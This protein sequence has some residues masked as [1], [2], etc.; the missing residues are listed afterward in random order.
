MYINFHYDRELN[1]LSPSSPTPC[2]WNVSLPTEL[3]CRSDGAE[4][5]ERNGEFP[6]DRCGNYR[7]IQ[8]YL[9]AGRGK[10]NRVFEADFPRGKCLFHLRTATACACRKNPGPDDGV[11]Y[12]R[13]L[14]LPL[15]AVLTLT[16]YPFRS[17]I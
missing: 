7:K 2:F 16:S 15:A 17:S 13:H 6:T 4:V 3:D 11:S 5:G 12:I 8:L 1:L 9:L 14:I 10:I